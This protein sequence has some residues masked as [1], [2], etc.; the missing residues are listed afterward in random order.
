MAKMKPP[1]PGGSISIGGQLFEADE[2][3]LVDLPTT[4][5]VDIARSHGFTDPPPAAAAAPD[6][7]SDEPPSEEDTGDGKVRKRPRR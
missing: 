5:Y 2:D 1:S 4:E 7:P 3:G 6:E